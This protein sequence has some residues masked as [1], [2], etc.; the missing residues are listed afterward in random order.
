MD[1]FPPT[2]QRPRLLA[3]ASKLE[4]SL[5]QLRRDECSDWTIYGKRGHVYVVP[6]GFQIVVT[7]WH[8]KGWNICKADLAFARLTQDGED[9]GAFILDRDPTP[10]ESE[11][12]RKWVGLKKKRQLDDETLARLADQGRVALAALRATQDAQNAAQQA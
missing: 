2:A 8:T 7:G 11:K 12:I 10:N 3:L 1:R 9:E 5:P 4:I 6:E